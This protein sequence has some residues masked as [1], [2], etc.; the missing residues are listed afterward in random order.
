MIKKYDIISPYIYLHYTEHSYPVFCEPFTYTVYT[1]GLQTQLYSVYTS[2]VGPQSAY[3]KAY[4][5]TF[6]FKCEVNIQ[7]LR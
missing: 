5:L 7:T 2:F 4:H 1:V 6:W 3:I